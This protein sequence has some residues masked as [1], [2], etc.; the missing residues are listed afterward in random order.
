[1]VSSK[2][3][4]KIFFVSILII[5]L[6]GLFPLNGATQNSS[7]VYKIYLTFD[8]GP[9]IGS[10][11]INNLINR[12]KIKANMFLIGKHIDSPL[13]HAYYELYRKNPYID[14]YNHSYT[15]AD[16]H[17]YR[18]YK[19]PSKVVSD[20]N[21]NQLEHDMMH[22]IIRLPGR[23]IW[24]LAPCI[25]NDSTNG[26]IAADSLAGLGYRIFGWDVEWQHLHGGRCIQTPQQMYCIIKNLALNNPSK[27][28]IKNHIVILIHDQ[29]FIT[30]KNIRL[31]EQFID[32]ITHDPQLKLEYLRFYP[33]ER[34]RE[35]RVHKLNIK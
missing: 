34:Q 25:R 20:I 16:E 27:L 31:L 21:K 14:I 1:M 7:V 24:R 6:L 9:L 33:W 35:N 5:L 30:S 13:L 26:E 32:L 12:K 29:M 11:Y 4:E 22:K 17:Y 28:F 18:F 15:H 8:D 19:N 10:N 3:N 2:D 23:N